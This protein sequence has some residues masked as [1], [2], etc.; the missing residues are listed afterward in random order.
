LNERGCVKITQ[1]DLQ[2]GSPAFEYTSVSLDQGGSILANETITF[3]NESSQ[4]YSRWEWYFG[5][6][7][8][9]KFPKSKDL[10]DNDGDGFTNYAEDELGFDKNDPA[11]FPLDSDGDGVPDGLPISD[12]VVTHEYNISGTYYTTLRIFNTSGCYDDITE[13]I[14]VGKGYYILKPNVFTPF[15]EDELNDRFS[16]LISGFIKYSF[17]I[18]DYKGNLVY[19]EINEEADPDN[20]SGLKVYGWD[21]QGGFST[22]GSTTLLSENHNGSPYYIYVF[23]GTLLKD[24]ETDPKVINNTGTFILLD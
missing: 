8:I 17:T 6:G 2:L 20:P 4:P 10:E 7:T 24:W 18:Y 1:L 5:D 3:S 12:E 19:H 23:E 14:S 22:N 11:D 16:L 15:E 13:P 21:A 9:K